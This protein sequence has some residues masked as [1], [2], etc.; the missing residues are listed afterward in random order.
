[1]DYTMPRADDVPPFVFST[2]NV[3]STADP[4]GVKGS[5]DGCVGADLTGGWDI[6]L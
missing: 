5:F 6:L 4:L 1:M 2:H 3:P